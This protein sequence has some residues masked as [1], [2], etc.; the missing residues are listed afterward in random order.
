MAQA[1]PTEN[2]NTPT[3]QTKAILGDADYSV[4]YIWSTDPIYTDLTNNID[5]Y[6]FDPS[7]FDWSVTLQPNG[8]YLFS[9]T[10]ESSVTDPTDSGNNVIYAG[11]GDDHVWAGAVDDVVYGDDVQNGLFGRCKFDAANDIKEWMAA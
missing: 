11:A 6:S 2:T 1:I 7:G 5:W 10:S 4:A 9:P 3:K 8:D